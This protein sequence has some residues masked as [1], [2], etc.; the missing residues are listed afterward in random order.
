MLYLEAEWNFDLTKFNS[1]VDVKEPNGLPVEGK[2]RT[3][4][5]KPHLLQ[6]FSSHWTVIYGNKTKLGAFLL[7][8][9]NPVCI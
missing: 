1:D 3:I 7:S 9:S 5:T 6:N 4:V 8:E 2:A